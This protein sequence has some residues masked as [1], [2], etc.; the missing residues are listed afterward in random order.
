MQSQEGYAFGG[1][2]GGRYA[3]SSM[4]MGRPPVWTMHR[5]ADNRVY[6]YNNYTQQSTWDKPDE[7]RTS[8]EVR[9]NKKKTMLCNKCKYDAIF[10][11]MCML[12][13]KTYM[14]LERI[15]VRDG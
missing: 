4:G 5:T 2:P 8:E 3:A 10:T 7:L 9:F 15:Y 14:Y 1:M 11:P 12:V 13:V 6:Y